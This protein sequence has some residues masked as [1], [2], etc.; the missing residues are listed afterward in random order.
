MLQK[1]IN[2]IGDRAQEV[3]KIVRVI[4]EIA[5]Q[6]NLL[7]LNAAI[8]AAR[9]G[10]AGRGFA[11]VADEV[12]RLAERSAGATQEIS[13]IIDRVQKDVG[14]S[15]KLT[16]EVLV[17]MVASLDNT[18]RVIEDSAQTADEQTRAT[19]T[20]LDTAERMSQLARQIALASKENAGSGN[21][22]AKAAQEMTELTNVM[23]DATIEQK[24]GGEMVVKATDS[25][26]AVARQNLAAVE[27]ITVAARNLAQEA[28]VLRGRVEEFAV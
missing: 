7:A 22:I 13:D 17:K 10:D 8:E 27:Q 3:S 15:V 12:R 21:E 28:E 14:G 5:D 18:S 4:E 26:A 19:K 25:I 2:G 9:A 23:L 6:T 20:M 24:K 1:S 16:E 11:V